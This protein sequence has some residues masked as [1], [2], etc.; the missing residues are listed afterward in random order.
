MLYQIPFVVWPVNVFI[1]KSSSWNEN[2]FKGFFH[3][4][5]DGKFHHR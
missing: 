2:L 4:R 1:G 3:G 5:N